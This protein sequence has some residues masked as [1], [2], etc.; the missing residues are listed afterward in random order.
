ML[1]ISPF[2]STNKQMVRY[3]YDIFHEHE[4]KGVTKR[5]R[6]GGITSPHGA[7]GI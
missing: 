1:I 4:T 3:M 5:R 2:E 7:G 6:G